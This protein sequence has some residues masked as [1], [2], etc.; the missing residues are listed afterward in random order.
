M[1]VIV[2]LPLI[3][4]SV[5]ARW[6][7]DLSTIAAT[8]RAG[9]AAVGARSYAFGSTVVPASVGKTYLFNKPAVRRLPRLSATHHGYSRPS[10][11]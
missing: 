3:G 4:S 8:Y 11:L 6:E 5:E 1:S 9:W 10:W 7:F 2:L